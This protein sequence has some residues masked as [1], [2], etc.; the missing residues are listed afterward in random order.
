MSPGLLISYV[1]GGLMLLSI[2]AFNLNMNQTTQEATISTINHRNMNNV[3]EIMIYDFSRLGYN[4]T[5]EIWTTSSVFQISS[6]DDVQFSVSD[7][8]NVRWYASPSDQVT[9]TTNPNDYYLYRVE[10]GQ[11]SSFPVTHFNITYYDGEDNEL[12]NPSGMGNL[13]ALKIEVE[14]IME[15]AEP[16]F[17]NRGSDTPI[18]H[19]AT[20][21]KVFMPANVN[22]PW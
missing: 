17:Q 5:P 8:G 7:V 15:S 22:K 14:I 18:Y 9:S 11:T 19:T 3:V 10:D 1:V 2:L 13:S 20:W 4:P 12:S 16:A 21:K 6:D